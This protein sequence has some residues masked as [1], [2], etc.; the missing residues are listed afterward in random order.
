MIKLIT[1]IICFGISVFTYLLLCHIEYMMW[2][3]W[4]SE[5]NSWWNI[6]YR[7]R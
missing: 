3:D 7:D 1:L 4:F 5:K 2:E 6:L